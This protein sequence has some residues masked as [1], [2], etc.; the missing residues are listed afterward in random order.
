M[1]ELCPNN[2]LWVD[3]EAFEEAAAAARRSR[4]LAAYRAVV[5]LYTGE[6]LPG[7]RYEDGRRSEGRS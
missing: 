6:L 1:L 3:V 7:D 4:E 2:A 5:E